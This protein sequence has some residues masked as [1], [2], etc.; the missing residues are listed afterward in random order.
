MPIEENQQRCWNWQKTRKWER[1]AVPTKATHF[2]FFFFFP[3]NMSYSHSGCR[4]HCR[5]RWGFLLITVSLAATLRPCAVTFNA[6]TSHSLWISQRFY[7]AAANDCA[8]AVCFVC[9]CVLCVFPVKRSEAD[10]TNEIAQSASVR[11]V[12]TSSCHVT[13]RRRPMLISQTSSR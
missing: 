13:F 7:C 9:V 11:R 4:V 1:R 8:R 10:E 3:G 2:F 6:I 5:S 12:H